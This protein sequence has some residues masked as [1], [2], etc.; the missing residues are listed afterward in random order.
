MK[1]N[2]KI[3]DMVKYCIN[4][5]Y[6]TEYLIVLEFKYGAVMFYSIDD[7]RIVSVSIPFIEKYT[8]YFKRLS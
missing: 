2:L 4:P 5:I 7:Q 6:E 3:G 8:Q 1:I